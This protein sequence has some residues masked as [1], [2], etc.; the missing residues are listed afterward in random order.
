MRSVSATSS[1]G[2][3]SAAIAANSNTVLIGM[4]WMPVR[5]YSSRAETFAST[6]SIAAARRVSR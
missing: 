6:S 4:S 5:S 3:R 1:A 2:S